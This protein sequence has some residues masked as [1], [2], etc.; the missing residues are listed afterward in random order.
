[1]R[2]GICT[3]LCLLIVLI[4][5]VHAAEPPILVGLDADL[6]SGSARSGVSIQRGIEL[7]M[8]E[9][10]E[11]GGVLGR[12]LQLV[13]RDHR[14]NPARGVDNINSFADIEGLVAVVGGLH[15]PVVLRELKPIHQHQIPFLIPWAAGTPVVE[16]GFDPNYVFRV[17]VRD[18][19][20]GGFLVGKALSKGYTKIG[21]LLERTG[22]GKSNLK[23]MSA[24]LEQ[25]QLD[26]AAVEW[27]HWGE[28][29]FAPILNNMRQKGI[30]AIL[31]VAN[32]PEAVQLVREMARQTPDSRLPI[33]SHWGITG[34]SF[35]QEV[36]ELLVDQVDLQF[37][38]TYSFL[39][40][41]DPQHS[42]AMAKRYCEKYRCAPG[43]DV[44]RAIFAPTGTA[45]AYDLIHLLA[46]ALEQAGKV[47][48]VELQQALEKI[49][50]YQGLVK[51]YSPPFTATMHDALS[52]EDFCMARYDED[53]VI[54][55]Q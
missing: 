7:A 35:H 3:V 9:I 40:P 52:V 11:Q 13:V 31:L 51:T 1:M 55:P 38:Q 36:G 48:R 6:S 44:E 46:V 33:L 20:A 47:G 29:N 39:Q 43:V 30:D 37:L 4:A 54:V 5:P 16:N 41:S 25:K 18:Q 42:T 15:T 23:A 24:A 50:V 19:Y 17:S 12:P 2:K 26:P 10:N 28:K 27:F 34:G 53:G 21:L 8:D 14:G 49:P 45:H 32:A 22:W